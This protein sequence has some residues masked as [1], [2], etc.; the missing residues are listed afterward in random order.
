MRRTISFRDWEI[1]VID[2]IAFRRFALVLS[3]L[4]LIM[5]CWAW[6]FALGLRICPPTGVNWGGR[7]VQNYL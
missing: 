7:F 4:V 1:S 6:L 3:F 2:S 5:S